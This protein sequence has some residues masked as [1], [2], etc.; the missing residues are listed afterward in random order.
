MGIAIVVFFL[1]IAAGFLFLGFLIWFFLLRRRRPGG[2]RR[3]Y[4]SPASSV[5]DFHNDGDYQNW[6]AGSSAALNYQS[7]ENERVEDESWAAE[8]YAY[9]NPDQ[10]E[11]VESAARHGDSAPPSDAWADESGSSS[12]DSGSTSDSGSSSSDSGS[13]SSGD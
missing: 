6:S 12:S 4:N 1:A 7:P 2:R 10:Y 11:S 5:T 13:G 3:S 9:G 8:S